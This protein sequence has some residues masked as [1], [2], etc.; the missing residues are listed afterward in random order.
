MVWWF[1]KIQEKEVETL[2]VAL[3]RVEKPSLTHEQK[4]RMRLSLMNT[5]KNGHSTEKAPSA[6]RS[7]DQQVSKV[8]QSVK[9]P[10]YV[11]A[12]MKERILE[13]IEKNR[14]PFFRP[15][16]FHQRHFKL[17]FSAFLLLAFVTTSVILPFQVPLIHAQ[18]FIQDVSG[19]VYVKRDG[20]LMK[21]QPDF[22]LQQGD[23][24]ITHA[25][26]SASVRFF[27]E[28]LGRLG[29]NTQVLIQKLTDQP[30][31]SSQQEVELFI[32][33]GRI[34]AKV[35]DASDDAQFSVKTKTAEAHVTKK[36]SFDMKVEDTGTSIQV[37]DNV[38]DVVK[39]GDGDNGAKKTVIAGYEA[40]VNQD[41]QKSVLIAQ[42]P[43]VNE[44]GITDKWVTENL[45][46]D[47]KDDRQRSSDV[48][49]KYNT[50]VT[51][52]SPNATQEDLLNAVVLANTE[53]EKQKQ[54]FLNAYENLLLAEGDLVRGNHQDG[55]KS[56]RIFRHD[57][58]VVIE[59]LP[60]L[61]K[62]D[63]FSASVLRDLISKTIAN[64]KTDLS[65]FLPG[66]KLYIAKK[67]VLQMEV[68]LADPNTFDK[69][70]VQ[71]GQAEGKLLEVQDLLKQKKEGLA[72]ADLR[73][74]QDLMA[75][76]VLRFPSAQY[77]DYNVE[78]KDIMNSQIEQVKVLAAIQKAPYGT[79]SEDFVNEVAKVRDNTLRSLIASLDPL[80]EIVPEQ[81]LKNLKDIFDTYLADSTTAEDFV[82]PALQKALS[83]NSRLN[84]IDPSVQQMPSGIGLVVIE[85]LE[86]TLD[87]TAVPAT[88][89]T[90]D[91][92][93]P[94][95]EEVV[96]FQP[97]QE[98]EVKPLEVLDNVK[99]DAHALEN[100]AVTI[101]PLDSLS[102]GQQA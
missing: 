48:E 13:A 65:I 87:A 3:K 80:N 89:E 23:K 60:D 98:K 64:Q 100:A 47:K 35:S 70:K 44:V 27:D 73:E 14:L 67:M 94:V 90:I 56:L 71:L 83:D 78:F 61:E 38:V 36:A 29:E 79:Y 37:F 93:P 82:S 52:P 68:S 62:Q 31:A 69:A 17:M 19:E 72:L 2:L 76:L 59:S 86:S 45:N 43:S 85:P 1:K 42:L 24:L 57:A 28:S 88:E 20:R 84:F 46:L 49:Q 4:D 77:A 58:G 5:I 16:A 66:D 33:Q 25:A 91:V 53:V 92:A 41:Q 51:L 50:N 18:A 63:P 21:A 75:S 81:D 39:P 7:L 10:A 26:S 55:A 40:T 12:A 96:E 15:M 97:T 101:D 34:W 99:V 9:L 54:D 32:D 6:L 102:N 11:A 30:L 95:T 8:V 74:Y 22:Y